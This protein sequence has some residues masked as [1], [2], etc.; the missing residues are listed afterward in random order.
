MILAVLAAC[1]T[2]CGPDEAVTADGCVPVGTT[3]AWDEDTLPGYQLREC[4]MEAGD[5]RMDF[6]AGCASGACIDEPYT[7]WVTALGQPDVMDP[8]TTRVQVEWF[9]AGVYAYFDDDNDDNRPDDTA[10][11][12]SFH[13]TERASGE[14]DEGLRID[15]SF[16]CFVQTLGDPDDLDLEANGLLEN[17]IWERD[18]WE[19]NV[20]DLYRR[21]NFDPDPDGYVDFISFYRR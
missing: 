9:D 2:T 8:G 10:L 19:L 1:T 13:T 6:I 15:I 11:P 5:G 18:G 17:L 3:V 21:Q 4:S 12:D 20:A 16:A 14:S 7:A